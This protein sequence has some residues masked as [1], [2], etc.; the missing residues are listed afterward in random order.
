MSDN[1]VLFAIGILFLFI[2]IRTFKEYKNLRYPSPF[3]AKII[4]GTI[5]LGSILTIWFFLK[6]IKF[7]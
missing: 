5:G 3:K 6:I 4:V 1:Y 2:G 7:V